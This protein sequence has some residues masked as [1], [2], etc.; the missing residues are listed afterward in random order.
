MDSCPVCGQSL[1]DFAEGAP[2]V[3]ELQIEDETYVGEEGAEM[4]IRLPYCNRGKSCHRVAAVN[5]MDRLAAEFK[6]SVG[7]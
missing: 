2:L 7:R 5:E 4:K 1:F 3:E 6:E